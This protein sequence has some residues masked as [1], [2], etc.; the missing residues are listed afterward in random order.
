MQ[1]YDKNLT[2]TE[3]MVRKAAQKPCCSPN[4]DDHP[5]VRGLPEYTPRTDGTTPKE[6]KR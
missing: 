3:V 5:E 4:Y 6:P 1:M 2:R